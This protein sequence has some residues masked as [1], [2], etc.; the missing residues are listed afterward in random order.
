MPQAETRIAE[1]FTHYARALV[2]LKEVRRHA[3]TINTRERQAAMN[4]WLPRPP[5]FNPSERALVGAWKQYMRWEESD[6]LELQ[7][8]NSRLLITR[9]RG[10]YRKALLRMRFFPEFWHMAYVWAI[11]AD[12]KKNAFD[13]LKDGI[14]ANPA[15]FVLNLALAEALEN[16][17]AHEFGSV[18]TLY[19]A[20]LDELRKGLGGACG[21]AAAAQGGSTS[22]ASDPQACDEQSF[23]IEDACKRRKEFGLVWINYMRFARRAQGAKAGRDVFR[24][25]R[26]DSLCPWNVYEA[27]ASAEYQATND[28]AIATRIYEAGQIRFGDDPEYLSRHLAF[29]LSANGERG[30]SI[31]ALKVV[32]TAVL[33]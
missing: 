3:S 19:T 21:S 22:T 1:N 16:E 6:P 7:S 8:H 30:N 5:T 32:S 4:V 12:T 29:V 10:V 28:A 25:A 13:I 26:L 15:S 23:A 27:A 11:D 9:I 14:A 31:C 24:A 2:A 33:T 18:H 17:G 20:L